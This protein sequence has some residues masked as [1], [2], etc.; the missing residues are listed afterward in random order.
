MISGPAA[1]YAATMERV[2]A[3]ERQVKQPSCIRITDSF[4]GVIS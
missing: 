4:M 3:I 1:D 2:E